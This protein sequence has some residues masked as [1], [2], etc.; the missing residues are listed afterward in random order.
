MSSRVQ[1]PEVYLI[2]LLLIIFLA[3]LFLP[4]QLFADDKIIIASAPKFCEVQYV[5]NV[6]LVNRG[7]FQV[8]LQDLGKVL[9]AELRNNDRLDHSEIMFVM[10]RLIVS[11]KVL[12]NAMLANK[13]VAVEFFIGEN[14]FS[15]SLWE[16]LSNYINFEF[17]INNNIIYSQGEGKRNLTVNLVEAGALGELL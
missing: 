15:N 13:G 6:I 17:R 14:F 2:S 4:G 8:C 10:D 1:T 16:K 9:E 11:D 3:A 5:N 12:K 7:P